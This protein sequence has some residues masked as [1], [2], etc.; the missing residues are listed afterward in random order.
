MIPSISDIDSFLKDFKQKM[1]IYSIFFKDRDKNEKTLKEL[2]ITPR[3]REEVLHELVPENYSSGPTPDAYDPESP[4][5]YVFGKFIQSRE[6][7]IKINMG[8]PEK[9][10][11]CI[12]FHLS[13]KPM[14]YPFNKRLR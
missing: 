7:Y 14:Q 12:S 1:S 9:R 8:K 11:M 5:N 4:P 3:Q 6:I 10:V 2:G 13:E